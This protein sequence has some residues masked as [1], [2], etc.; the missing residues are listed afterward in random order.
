MLSRLADAGIDL[1]GLNPFLWARRNKWRKEYTGEPIYNIENPMELAG[2]LVVAVAKCDGDMSSEEKHYILDEF[3]KEFE[4]SKGDA[5]G[6]M[7]SSVYLLGRGDV[8]CENLDKVIAPSKDKFTA[9]QA[10]TTIA[11]LEKVAAI[12]SSAT[13]IQN[14]IVRVVRQAL[15]KKIEPKGKWD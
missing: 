13:D 8:L 12:G 3:Q 10:E 15:Q 14:E 9:A 4:L 11:M 2:L 7:S 5:S 6:L 1:R